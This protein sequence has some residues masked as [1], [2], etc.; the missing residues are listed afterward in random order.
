MELASAL[1]ATPIEDEDLAR[2]VA[3]AR[4]CQLDERGIDDATRLALRYR[5]V[6]PHTHYLLVDER[7][8]ADKAIDMSHLHKVA[9]MPPA[10]WGGLGGPLR[11]S[12]RLCLFE[13][14][15]IEYNAGGP[16]DW[17]DI[18]V[19]PGADI[20]FSVADGPDV[21]PTVNMLA[22]WF[23]KS[24]RVFRQASYW[25]DGPEGHGL[26]PLGLAELLQITPTS[27]WPSS[28]AGLRRFGL[29]MQVVEWLEL[30]GALTSPEEEVVAAFLHLMSQVEVQR[31]LASGDGVEQ[32]FAD[33]LARM[34]TSKGS[35]AGTIAAPS[36][37]VLMGRI[38]Y[39]L[40][41]AARDRW[42]DAVLQMLP[43]TDTPTMNLT[44]A[45]K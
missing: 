15:A 27:A 6:S 31:S 10:G 41:E 39:A 36:D 20:R 17:S 3:A 7:V 45:V 12:E 40:K 18:D 22:E 23:G 28:Y 44:T 38:A 4:I 19:P 25:S 42:P 14:R 13:T 29:G 24:E 34:S 5:L 32:A 26:T 43:P 9:Q 30:V 33:V 35:P 2:V 16:L 21:E 37:M 8:A 11:S 1:L